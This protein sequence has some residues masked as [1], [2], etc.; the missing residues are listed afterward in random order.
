MRVV[1][2]AEIQQAF[3]LSGALEL[4][5]QIYRMSAKGVADVSSPAAISMRGAKDSLTRFKVKG[6]VLDELGVAG[7]RLIGDAD[8]HRGS[9]HAYCYLVDAVTTAPIALVEEEWLHGV[10]TALTGI[11]TIEAL[12]P[13]HVD[14]IALLGT[15]RIARHIAA[16]LVQTNPDCKIVVTSRSAER[17]ADVAAKWT[18]ELGGSFVAGKSVADAVRQAR[19][20][21]TVSDADERLFTA[22]DLQPGTLVCAM[23]GR[24]EFD[25][26]VLD[27]AGRFIVDEIDFV[28]TAGNVAA[29][30]AAGSTSRAAI[31][32]RVDATIGQVLLADQ[33]APTKQDEVCLAVIQGMAACDI[34][35]A[36]WIYDRTR[37]TTDASS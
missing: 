15:G 13:K 32:T 35:L 31:E 26:D 37:G 25:R 23:G 8:P 18:T 5:R 17:A 30:I 19:V 33:P 6:A 10:R 20:V 34:G 3:E 12:K 9:D 36:K 7:F 2:Q 11:V 14:T 16:F 27:R 4:I 21:V 29:W 24:R 28:C 22:D 1:K